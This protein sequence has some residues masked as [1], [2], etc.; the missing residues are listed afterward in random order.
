MIA[1]TA[2]QL[3]AP[4]VTMISYATIH[5]WGIQRYVV[6]AKEAGVAGAIVPDL[7]IEQAGALSTACAAHDLS[8]I[9]LVTPTTPRP[10]AVEI[11]SRS[12]GFLYYVAVTGI[13]G[14]RAVLPT[15]LADNV[16]WLRT[17]TDLPICVGFGISRVE[18]VRL[19]SP[20]ADGLIVGSAIVRRIAAAEKGGRAEVI[21]DIGSHVASLIA[22]M[23]PATS[24]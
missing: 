16:A 1:R 8:L 9:Q 6:A 11:A 22:A 20:V 14:E 21:E 17:Q 2:P 13:T 19:L 15:E 18:H 12:S 7:P 3:D 24:A 10:R 4:L 23:P 5:R